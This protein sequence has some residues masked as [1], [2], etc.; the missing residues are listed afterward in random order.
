M[1]LSTETT[2]AFN[3]N[4][5]CFDRPQYIGPTKKFC[6]SPQKIPCVIRMEKSGEPTWN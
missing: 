1:H 3:G 5:K 6:Y 2:T 4:E